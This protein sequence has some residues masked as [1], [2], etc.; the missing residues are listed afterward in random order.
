VL[1]HWVDPGVALYGCG[2]PG[3]VRIAYVRHHGITEKATTSEIT[4]IVQA[5]T[6]TTSLSPFSYQ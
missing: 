6:R 1:E 2:R 5:R 3:E 4:A